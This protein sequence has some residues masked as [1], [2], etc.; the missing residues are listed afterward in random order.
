M[1]SEQM[2]PYFIVGVVAL[3]AAA[4]QSGTGLG[5]AI[6]SMSV[7]QML[8][9]FRTASA[10]E[11]I[12]VCLLC[13]TLLIRLRRHVRLKALITPLIATTVFLPLGMHTMMIQVDAFMRQLMG[14]LLLALCV[15][16]IFFGER[17]RVRP[18]IGNGLIAGA[19]S[20][21]LG[22]MF[23]IGGPP[24]AI[25]FLSTTDDK[26]EY[27]ASLQAIFMLMAPYHI[28]LHAI[29][30]N[31]TL[32]TL[33]FS[34]AAVLGMAVGSVLGFMV[35]KRLSMP[36]LKRV[37]YCFMAVFGLYLVISG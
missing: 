30:G 16:F 6:I 31:I 17:F 26:L 13:V 24:L 35:F 36:V 34:A 8:M 28:I 22:G 7:W 20:G 2:T 14:I 1:I 37:V 11:A 4:F 10:V 9:P 19:L 32:Q 21:F 5:Y 33:R 27:S 29:W 18:T 15:Y 3:V 12:T 25:Y 23:N